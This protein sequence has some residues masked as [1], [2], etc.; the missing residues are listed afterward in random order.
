M[1]NKKLLFMRIFNNRQLI[2]MK[3]ILL[4][5]LCLIN[6][7]IALAQQIII[8]AGGTTGTASNGAT[9]DS[10]PM[11]RSGSTSNFVYSS[12]HYL[13]TQAELS[14]AGLPPG[15]IITNLAWNKTNA[16][17][18]NAPFLFQIWMQNSS[19]S[20]VPAPPQTLAGLTTSA[21]QVYNNAATTLSAAIGYV[22]FTLTGTPFLYT[23]GA[24]EIT[25]NFDM[26]SG[27]NPWT[28]DGIS[29]AR[30]AAT[31]RTI[32]YVGSTANTTLSNLRTVRPQL[33][34]TYMP[35]SPCT[36]PP[37]P[38]T[39]TSSLNTVCSGDAV[40]LNLS[41]NSFGSGQTYQWQSSTTQ[42]GTYTNFGTSSNT[43][44]TTINPTATMWYQ[45]A[46]T[47]GASTLYSVPKQVVVPGL[48]PGGTYTINSAVATGGTNFQT[49]ADAVNAIKC[50]IAGPVVFNV[51]MGSGPYNEKITIPHSATFTSTNTVTFNG[52]GA[53]ITTVGAASGDN[54]ITLDGADY[55]K[56][57]NLKINNTGTTGYCVWLTNNAD[58]NTFDGCTMETN[59]TATGS[60]SSVMGVGCANTS[61]TTS[62]TG[63]CDNNVVS[64]CTLIGGY[65]GISFLGTSTSINTGNKL[66]NCIVR[67]Q[68][69]Y[70]NYATYQN[71]LVIQGND[72]YNTTAR[73]THSTFY[74][75][76]ITTGCI[77]SLIDKNKVHDPAPN[78]LTGTSTFYCIYSGADGT[79]SNPNVFS[80][81][82]VYN[83]KN[84][85]SHYG[86]YNT[87]ADYALYYYNSVTLDYTAA[88]A[89]LAYAFY[90]TT[91]A[92][93]IQLKNNILSVTKG[94][95]GAMY[96]VF[97]NTTGTTY[98]LDRNDYYMA[99]ASTGAKG[100]GS[101][102]GTPQTTLA[103]WATAASDPNSVSIDPAFTDATIGNLA[104]TAVT[105][106]NKGAPITGITT[107]I[108]GNT[109]SATTPDVGAYEFPFIAC[110]APTGLTSGSITA[111]TANLSWGAVAGSIGYEYAVT[112]SATPP[113][114]GT[115]TTGLTYNT[116]TYTPGTVY[117]LHVRNKCS[118][119]SF[120]AWTTLS[121]TTLCPAPAT[122]SISSITASGATVN[123]TAVTGATGYEYAVTTSA[124]PPATGTATTGTTHSPNT[125]NQATMYYVHLRTKCQGT[126]FSAWTTA[127]FTT[128][129]CSAPA[130][131]NISG[132]N[133]SGANISWT[134]VAGAIGYEYAVTTSATPPASGTATTGT[135]HNPATLS[136]GTT[137][138]VHLRTQ[139][140]ATTFSGWT[141]A[142][143][144]TQA[145]N[146]PASPSITAVTYDGANIN[147]GS[148]ASAIG[149]EY[150]VTTGSTPPATGTATTGT[151]Y[152][153]NSLLGSTTYYVHLRTQCAPGVYSPWTTAN[154]TTLAPPCDPVTTIN[155]TGITTSGANINWGAVAGALGYEYA[156][157]TSATPPATGTATTGTTHTPTT[158]SSG[159]TYYVHVR[160]Q[161]GAS[162]FSVWNTTSFMTAFPPCPDV[163]NIA[164]SGV[165]Y[166][167]AT[168]NWATVPSAIDYE[169]AIT[170]SINPPANGIITTATSAMPATL[171]PGTSYYVHVRSRCAG[172]MYSAWQSAQFIT[173]TCALPPAV[174]ATNITYTSADVSW[175]PVSG[176]LGYEYA[177]NN[178]STPPASGIA[179]NANTINAVSLIPNTTY[180][181]H[182]RNKC[183]TDV[184]SAWSTISFN[185][186]ACLDITPAVQNTG[187]TSALITW[188]SVGANA[189]EY[190]VSSSSTP[191][192]T[193]FT[194][195]DTSYAAINLT[196][197]NTYHVHLRVR[198]IPG[199]FSPWQ[200]VSFVAQGCGKPEGVN[201][202]N[203]TST[204][205]T[206]E[207]NSAANAQSYEYAI[208]VNGG[209]P[210]NVQ[211]TT[212]T[213][214]STNAL[215]VNTTY[216][217]HVRSVCGSNYKSDWT[218]AAFRTTNF[219][220]SI[221]TVDHNIGIEAYPNPAHN[222]VTVRV[223]GASA[224]GKIQ[225]TDIA[226]RILNTTDVKAAE[227]I[228]DI[229]R[230]SP[231]IYMIK[232]QNENINQ[233][234]KINK[235]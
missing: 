6:L 218:V 88:T 210:T 60:A 5:C 235:Q 51:A 141:T 154:F 212:N 14:A 230:L 31:D 44:A 36:A 164:I 33:R 137:Y 206:V 16:A 209:S 7:N 67:D 80:N 188:P 233:T 226:G 234:L 108:L 204:G 115:S 71:G 215:T 1:D 35:G 172:S 175:N 147:W 229:S 177:V 22:D 91:A 37:N 180:Y 146:A 2:I 156:V 104:P 79:V 134:P 211:A 96:P 32:S 40:N 78:G 95:T 65:T 143:F 29:W 190:I 148:V 166:T 221:S 47:C 73:A 4:L 195:T 66:L 213:S 113:A 24:L 121:F 216:N 116:G 109:R 42:F 129:S 208:T 39:T 49:F 82:I 178:T 90:Q 25:V 184:Y 20:T 179:T 160:T 155:I 225:L 200:T 75:P 62:G 149:Y 77:G 199:V 132:V 119:S 138:Y 198:C 59:L 19:A 139:C 144:T 85:G 217:I 170:T 23:G 8:G 15:S 162:L 140:G 135:T 205:A 125:L 150:A 46:V 187:F 127:N 69:V 122:P 228:L 110:V 142:S 45:C 111:T 101:L 157:T 54:T 152:N 189:Y 72:M 207:W 10:G 9:G 87:G 38:G 153:A 130:T 145:C 123:W 103:G 76:M 55:I 11:Y 58:N 214:V 17:A 196:T 131:P 99:S 43:P 18:S 120:S 64:N 232:Y 102:F 26:S 182:V 53:I 202:S 194:T 30:D 186:R 176:S 63:D 106:D 34:I 192:A 203:I 223:N 163:T 168:I 89:G 185:T 28:T 171:I 13:Y 93:G 61:T 169:Y 81:N 3:K 183:A 220:N 21:S 161:C 74:G 173:L 193:G 12:H 222:T 201:V 50:G 167:G 105:L 86:L 159:T 126:I 48:F 191:P 83:I 100:I 94:G 68:Y 27:T 174:S 112:T 52:N 92:T 227:T 117:Y 70:R 181:I 224:N 114:T 97:F 136:S 118:A 133:Y 231:G 158:L 41:G 56:F 107:D 151:S 124:T 165:S 84:S 197:G 57:N 128:L 98:T 219:P